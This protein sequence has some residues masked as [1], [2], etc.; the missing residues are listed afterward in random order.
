MCRRE[1]NLILDCTMFLHWLP[2]YGNCIIGSVFVCVCVCAFLCVIHVFTT[3]RGQKVTEYKSK[4]NYS[5]T[6][7]C[8]FWF[9]LCYCMS[10]CTTGVCI[11]N[12]YVS[13]SMHVCINLCLFVCIHLHA[14]FC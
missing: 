9:A 10:V 1:P 6:D 3:S 11:L 2:V 8:V 5:K 12:V 4:P 13:V 14:P 7:A